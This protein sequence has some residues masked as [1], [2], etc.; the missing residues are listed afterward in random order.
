[1]PT[2]WYA[3]CR[4][5]HHVDVGIEKQDVAVECSNCGC[6]DKRVAG[7]Y[8]K[9]LGFVTS[10]SDRHGSDPGTMRKRQRRADEAKLI[11]RPL[12]GQLIETDV[13][14]VE[15]ALLRAQP[16]DDEEQTGK[17]FILNRGPYGLGYHICSLCKYIANPLKVRKQLSKHT[18]IL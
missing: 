16:I 10:Y 9:P 5:C 7:R 14:L 11:T 3:L 13:S 15:K 6:T 12:P 8:I 4:E 1:M 2:E 17:L 18:K